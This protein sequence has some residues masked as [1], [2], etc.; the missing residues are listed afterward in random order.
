MKEI[1]PDIAGRADVQRAVRD[2][3][4]LLPELA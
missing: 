2:I 3:R 4:T 1:I